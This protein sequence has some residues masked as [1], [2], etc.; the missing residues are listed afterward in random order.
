MTTKFEVGKEYRTRDGRLARVYA[1]DG[2]PVSPVHGAIYHNKL[3]W[4]ICGWRKDG[5]KV[6]HRECDTDIMPEKRKVWVA[7]W[8]AVN[9]TPTVV[10][11]QF[12]TRESALEWVGGRE[13]ISLVEVREL[14]SLVEV[15]VPDE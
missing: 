12:A 10:S 9:C 3:G 2:G 6:L 13:L 11:Q 1:T 14:I 5:K 15:E 4:I 8:W 7:T